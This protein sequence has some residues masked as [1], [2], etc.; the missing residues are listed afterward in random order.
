MLHL[1]EPPVEISGNG[2]RSADN[3]PIFYG[4]AGGADLAFAFHETASAAVLCKS[5]DRA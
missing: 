3:T 5:L 1:V 2:W 4:L